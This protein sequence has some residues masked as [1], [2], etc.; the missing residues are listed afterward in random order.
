MSGNSAFELV[1][2]R[3]WR[4]GLGNMLDSEMSHWWKTRRWW[5]NSLIWSLA[6]GLVLGGM[7][8]GS[9]GQTPSSS[10]VAIV[11]PIFAGMIP[12]VFV[13][14]MMQGAV[15]GEKKDGTAA[16]VL[17][18]PLSRP[19]FL[20]SKVFANGLGV[21]ATAVIPPGIVAYI[22]NAVGS[23]TPWNPWAFLAALGVL[24]LSIFYF[25]SLTLML[26][27]LFNQRGPVIGIALGLLLL[28]QYLVQ[29]LP[30]LGYVLPWSLL[31]PLKEPVDAVV[32][33]LLLGTHNYSVIPIV[34][35]TVQIILFLAI[36]IYRFNKEEF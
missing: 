28:Q 22:L 10:E 33:N 16:W 32:P 25:L 31:I 23:G 36:A 18:K 29:L 17:S 2:E 1:K 7:L 20:L 12:T 15:V 6:V 5:V 26:G 24:F 9:P 14:I 34:A 13:I 30:S 8:F 27:T 21:L 35:V 19:A 3:G 4:R 11:Y